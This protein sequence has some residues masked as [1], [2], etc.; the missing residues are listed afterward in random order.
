[1]IGRDPYYV[2]KGWVDDDRHVRV[3]QSSLRIMQSIDD[4]YGDETTTADDAVTDVYTHPAPSEDAN[5]NPYTEGYFYL[6]GL[7]D[8]VDSMPPSPVQE[9]K[10]SSLTVGESSDEGDSGSLA[11]VT[12][13]KLKLHFQPPSLSAQ[14]T[15]PVNQ[16]SNMYTQNLP[17]GSPQPIRKDSY[18][19]PPS[20]AAP[21]LEL[22][23]R[24]ESTSTYGSLAT[25][26]PTASFPIE[27]SHRL[28]PP[29]P[30][31]SDFA[32][33]APNMVSLPMTSLHNAAS[34]VPQHATGYTPLLQNTT[35]PNQPGNVT[36]SWSGCPILSLP[37]GSR[38][39][40]PIP[41][42]LHPIINAIQSLRIIGNTDHPERRILKKPY[43][44]TYE[45][46]S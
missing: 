5:D 23:V 33:L 18:A 6:G 45:T 42:D 46:A 17:Y 14:S 30:T 39:G 36:V 31:H 22:P 21:R 28:E 40:Q 35:L 4:N 25:G 3:V 26:H 38:V 11:T 7:V 8:L 44:G 29:I 41:H 32:P 20:S 10:S 12:A 37:N 1:M 24:H 13:S 2:R 15:Y 19:L 27:T 16:V 9:T 43:E 34:P